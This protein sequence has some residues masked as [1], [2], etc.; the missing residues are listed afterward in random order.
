MFLPVLARSVLHG[1]CLIRCRNDFPFVGACDS[2]SFGEV[3]VAHHFSIM[4][5]VVCSVCL[6]PVSYVSNFA[7]F[8]GLSILVVVDN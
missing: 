7:S 5:C 6:R 2:S 3:R 8:S 4:C 1:G